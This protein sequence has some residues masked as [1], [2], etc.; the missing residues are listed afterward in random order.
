MSELQPEVVISTQGAKHLPS[1]HIYIACS[2]NQ[3]P[4]PQHLGCLALS[5][6]S[7][8]NM[9]IQITADKKSG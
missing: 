7:D 2:S 3:L 4:D 5:Y 9:S 6:T 1:K 8:P